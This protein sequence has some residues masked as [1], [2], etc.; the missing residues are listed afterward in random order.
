MLRQ[1]PSWP[2]LE[3]HVAAC[4]TSFPPGHCQAYDVVVPAGISLNALMLHCDYFKHNI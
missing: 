1:A 3:R 2:S 4:D